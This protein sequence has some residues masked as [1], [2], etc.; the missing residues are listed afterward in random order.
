[1]ATYYSNINKT[2][3]LTLIVNQTGQSVANNTSTISYELRLYNT[4]PSGW[5]R[6]DGQV[7]S[8]YLN[9]NG[10]RIWTSPAW[11]SMYNTDPNKY[12]L[13]ASGTRTITHGSD[14][15]KQVPLQAYY[16]ANSGGHGPLK[17]SINTSLTLTDI[18]RVSEPSLDKSSV[19]YGS[20][21]KI[22]TNRKSTAF[23]H[24]IKYSNEGSTGT[25]ATGVGDSY[26][27]TV[28][29]SHMSR[30][31]SKTSSTYR[32]TIDTISGGSVVGTKTLS[33]TATV[34]TSY[35]PTVNTPTH[36]DTNSTQYNKYKHYV[37]HHS[38][39]KFTA[40]YS[41]RAYATITS[42]KFDLGGG[43][44]VV[45]RSGGNISQT[46]ASYTTPTLTFHTQGNSSSPTNS[47][48]YLKVTVTDSRGRSTT[49]GNSAA[50]HIARYDVPRVDS[51]SAYRINTAGVRDPS[52]ESIR[53][54][55]KVTIVG[56]GGNNNATYKW[57][58][59]SAQQTTAPSTQTFSLS[60]PTSPQPNG[61]YVLTGNSTKTGISSHLTWYVD[62]T[63]TDTVTGRAVTR[64]VEVPTGFVTQSF[65]A[66]GKGVAFGKEATSDGLDIS[67]DVLFNG[68][69]TALGRT[70]NRRPVTFNSWEDYA[71]V[72]FGDTVFVHRDS[73]AKPSGAP[74]NY[75]NFM[76]TGLR[77]MSDGWTGIWT[78]YN[79]GRMW[80]G[81]VGT[82]GVTPT[83][84]EIDYVG[85]HAKS[86]SESAVIPRNANMNSY[87]TP[88]FYHSNLNADMA[89]VA[90]HPSGVAGSLMVLQ[91]ADAT[92]FWVNFSTSDTRMY[93][94]NQYGSSWGA[95]S[96]VGGSSSVA[97]SAVTGKPST[98]APSSHT[99]PYQQLA[100][101]AHGTTGT[102]NNST[103]T[104]V[105][106]G[107]TFPATPSVVATGV[108]NVAGDSFAK[109]RN[110]N[111]TGFEIIVGGVGNS[112]VFNWIAIATG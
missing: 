15:K 66:G 46:T 61:D 25:I 62:F 56:I 91:N 47:P 45:T 57:S 89:T 9:I 11:D 7:Q 12:K 34:P 3:R 28:P 30:I 53:V 88:G 69:A 48:V 112:N 110:R 52:G 60:R 102:I 55:W 99:H 35:K 2:Y 44:V 71:T 64:S 106:F 29:E 65:R 4:I 54:N 50:M 81:A 67:M 75:L 51:F 1:M 80:V 14:G 38:K 6:F 87:T 31:P 13:L 84:R 32:L 101:T 37:Q 10:T 77:D 103:W 78:E 63:V 42:V 24:T 82:G 16:S 90:N 83:I 68:N 19:A 98:F 93:V 107:K 73:T 96:E 94:R 85:R 76:K 20:S 109:I 58:Y 97:W 111:T 8:G 40:T 5:T 43:K 17:L 49:S 27:Y 23:T 59:R 104:K 36:A 70:T 79:T 39:S 100:R 18:P 22:T 21:I 95:W 74:A 26:T 72:P 92:Q 86:P 105:S 108:N 33:F 41:A